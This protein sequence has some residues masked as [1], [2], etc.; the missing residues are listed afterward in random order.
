MG[1]KKRSPKCHLVRTLRKT[2][3]F[4]AVVW[5]FMRIKCQLKRKIRTNDNNTINSGA[6]HPN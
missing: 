5:Y 6:V 3:N 1:G 2:W 4:S